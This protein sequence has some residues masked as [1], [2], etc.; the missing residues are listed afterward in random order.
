MPESRDRWPVWYL[1][2]FQIVAVLVIAR[3]LPTC[4]TDMFPAKEKPLIDFT[5]DWVSA[6]NYF[7]GRSIYAPH[8]ETYPHYFDLSQVQGSL[9][10]G[11]N[12]HPPASVLVILPLG[13]LDFFT[14]LAIWHILSLLALC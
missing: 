2:V 11:Y 14:A 13:W 9:V 3:Y 7:E 12:A 8:T 6:R 1:L 10:L 4:A 5:Q